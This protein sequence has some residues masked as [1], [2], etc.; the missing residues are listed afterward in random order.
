MARQ[1][2]GLWMAFVCAALAGPL[3]LAAQN[4]APNPDFDHN[5]SGWN[6]NQGIPS[7]IGFDTD[8]CHLTLG[9]GA[10]WMYSSEDPNTYAEVDSDC[11]AVTP[12]QQLCISFDFINGG[13]ENFLVAFYYFDSACLMYSS[14]MMSTPTSG[15]SPT[16]ATLE[17]C[18]SVPATVSGVSLR[19]V[20][21]SLFAPPFTMIVDRVYAG[22]RPRIFADDFE[23]GSFCRWTYAVP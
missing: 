8:E 1:S 11:F 12:S 6:D 9:S 15:S 20:G 16:F 23:P 18:G 7:W 4:L 21:L 3:P 17:T 2:V 5:I 13:D 10:L 22:S 14:L 19:P